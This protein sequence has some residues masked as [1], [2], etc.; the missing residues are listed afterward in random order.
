MKYYRLCIAALAVAAS[1]PSAVSAAT[2][3][4][5]SDRAAFGAAAGNTRTE[6]FNSISTDI[7][8][9]QLLN[10]GAFTLKNV[11]PSG[12]HGYSRVDAAPFN[13]ANS[14]NGTT[15]IE[16]NLY[17][18]PGLCESFLSVEFD[19]AITAFGVDFAG[20]FDVL[21]DGQFLNTYSLPSGFFGFISDTPFKRIEFRA[22]QGTGQRSLI[23]N[24]TFSAAGVP[25]P[26]TWAMMIFGMGAVGAS[27]RR[28]RASKIAFV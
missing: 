2:L 3:V 4:K 28:R 26:A 8:L 23:D 19:S 27:M 21:V 9:S 13:G 22:N 17:S 6:N 25:E 15:Y 24:F 18:M 20:Y 12:P 5:Y 10:M 7:D 16:N 14:V 11:R 1:I